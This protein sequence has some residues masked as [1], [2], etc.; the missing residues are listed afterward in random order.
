MQ[1]NIFEKS[2]YIL[3]GTSCFQAC[4]AYC[5]TCEYNSNKS[6][7][8]CTYCKTSELGFLFSRELQYLKEYF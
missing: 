3:S 2:G 4:G 1:N 7:F 8:E 5:E 6:K